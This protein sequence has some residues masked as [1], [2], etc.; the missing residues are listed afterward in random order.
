M[1]AAVLRALGRRA[2]SRDPCPV[3]ELRQ[4]PARWFQSR[5]PRGTPRPY[6]PPLQ[7]DVLEVIV[8]PPVAAKAREEAP[9][10]HAGVSRVR[11]GGAVV[12]GPRGWG[13]C[14]TDG[15]QP[16]VR[17]RGSR[18]E[19]NPV[20]GPQKG[21]ARTPAPGRGNDPARKPP[22]DPARAPRAPSRPAASLAPSPCPVERDLETRLPQRASCLLGCPSRRRTPWGRRSP[23]ARVA[24]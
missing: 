1:G 22:R 12:R 7:P 21:E 13:W 17:Y 18:G 20:Q 3:C 24:P 2:V 6:L 10:G 15:S 9:A 8:H 5:A 4:D 14:P 16:R 23:Q 11:G 19:K